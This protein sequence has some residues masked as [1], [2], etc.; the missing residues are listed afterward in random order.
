MNEEKLAI[1]HKIFSQAYDLKKENRKEYM[2]KQSDDKEII[3]YVQAL[4]S[5]LDSSN[6]YFD[7]FE[8]F[9]SSSQLNEI[10]DHLY[11]DLDFGNYQIINVMKQGGMGTIFLARRSDGEFQREVVIKMI[12]IDLNSQLAQNQFAHEKEILA[13]LSHPNI[14]QLYDSGVSKNEQPYFVM[15]FVKGQTIID[16]SI[17]NKLCCKQRI[18]LFQT[19]L[20]AVAFAH[21]HLVIHG[22]IK[23]SNI[24]VNTDAQIKL[25]DF[26]IARLLNKNIENSTAY[27]LNYLTPEHKE[28]K[29]ITTTTDIHQ[30]GQ[31][32]YE[33]ITGVSA[34]SLVDS[35]FNYPLI[36]QIKPSKDLLKDVARHKIINSDLQYIIAKALA[37]KPQDRYTSIHAFDDDINLYLNNNCIKAKDNNAVVKIKKSIQRNKI[38]SLFLASLV[39]FSLF[40][41]IIIARHNTILKHERDKALDLKN[42]ISEVF[43]A[44]D[45]TA[46]PGK[47]LTATEVL[48]IGL[49]KVQEK[50]DGISDNQADLLQEISKTYQSLGKYAKAHDILQQVYEIK[51]ELHPDDNLSKA[52]IMLLLG[53]NSR[54]MSKN[55]QAKKWLQQSLAIFRQNPQE[56]IIQLASVKSKLGRVLVLL[57]DF[58]TAEKML[59]EATEM[60]ESNFG[61]TSIQYAQALNDLNSVY[62]RQGKYPQVQK[63]L[64]Q[65][66]NIREKL[67]KSGNK[68]ILD[69]DY[70]TNINNLGLSYYL[71][72]KLKPAEVYFRQ[73]NDLRNKIYLKPHPEQAQSLTNLGLLLND[74]GRYSEALDYLQKALTIRK[75]TLNEGHVRIFDAYNNL[76]M[77]YHENQE[78]KKADAIYNNILNKAIISRGEKH[79]QV[80]AITTNRANTLLMLN[81]IQQAHDLFQKSLNFRLETLPSDHLYLSYSY[82]GLGKAKV[83]LGETELGKELIKKAIEIRQNK[84]PA[85][86]WLIGEAL[87]AELKA[88]KIDNI[89]DSD[90]VKETC[91]IL[92]KTKGSK[93]SLTIECLDLLSQSSLCQGSCR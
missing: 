65:S 79:P 64:I 8:N 88:E 50:F 30:L 57:S 74:S 16:Y 67:N 62:F 91:D 84:L 41:L 54:L 75:Q 32:I 78:F 34:N 69:K 5:S 93:H 60:I 76:A 82:L 36:S 43:S 46:V 70:A 66:K 25:L 77:V 44:A 17:Q 20:K 7:D 90:K 51:T 38:L 92:N 23:P 55:N 24:M 27:S 18:K 71:Q 49:K 11:R 2:K 72:G 39:I 53:D 3:T 59:L 6:N 47:E 4:F 28:K 85:K 42:L 37:L 12:P 56:N 14:V 87:L 21:Q 83:L 10:E 35:R 9:V 86:H 40:F 31:L 26:G 15:E 61:K 33:L 45:P 89:I 58:K 80:L 13:S 68:E 22:D 73:A 52:G 29:A 81:K 63:L 1:A 48:D 19:V